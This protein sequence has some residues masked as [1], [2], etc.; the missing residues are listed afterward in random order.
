[1]FPGRTQLWSWD[2]GWRNTPRASIS[3]CLLYEVTELSCRITTGTCWDSYGK[4]KS[5][6]YIFLKQK[7]EVLFLNCSPSKQSKCRK[8]FFL[9]GLFA[10]HPVLLLGFFVQK[11]RCPTPPLPDGI[12][13]Q[14]LYKCY[15]PTE[16]ES[17]YHQSTLLYSHKTIYCTKATASFYSA[18]MD[19]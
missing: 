18:G 10:H 11:G 14:F 1:M 4:L 3:S 8:A 15:V 7:R 19:G 2:R 12:H 6:R 9:F 16:R 13:S 17:R 5:S